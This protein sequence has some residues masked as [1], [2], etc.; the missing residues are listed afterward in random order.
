MRTNIFK[1]LACLILFILFVSSCDWQDLP[2]YEQAEISAV[3]FYYRWASGEKDAVTGEPI[4]KE[5]RL[6]T[7]SE[8]DSGKGLVTANVTVPDASGDFSED[9]RADVSQGRLWGQVSV[10]TAARVTPVNGT[11]KLG[12]PDDWTKERQFEVRAAD[13]TVKVWTIKIVEFNK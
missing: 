5:K 12:T 3:Q 9:V 4:V 1:A 2:S 13:G 7:V 6:D 10:S 11:A 8:V